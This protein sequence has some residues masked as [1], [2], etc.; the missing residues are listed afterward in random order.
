MLLVECLIWF[1]VDFCYCIFNYDGGE[2]EYC[3]N[4]V[5]CFVK[6]VIDCG[7]IDKCIVCVE[8]MNGIVILMM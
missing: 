4:G 5:C 8:V 7:L 6:F 2:V 3:G 1:D